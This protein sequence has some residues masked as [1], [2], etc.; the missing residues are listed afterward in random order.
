MATTLPECTNLARELV[1]CLTH[2]TRNTRNT[3]PPTQ[4]AKD[5]CNGP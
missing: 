3:H 1:T 5:P 2:N 4:S